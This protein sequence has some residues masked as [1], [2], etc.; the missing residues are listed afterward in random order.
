MNTQTTEI[1]QLVADTLPDIVGPLN[2]TQSKRLEKWLE[3]PEETGESQAQARLIEAL[4]SAG[5]RSYREEGY[6]PEDLT[7]RAVL[8]S[9]T[10]KTQELIEQA[11]AIL[12][13]MSSSDH[14]DAHVWRTCEIVMQQLDRIEAWNEALKALHRCAAGEG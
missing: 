7:P 1:R 8:L 14:T 13:F 11:K 5:Y 12:L 4:E 10:E 6:E 3:P 9:Q 2:K